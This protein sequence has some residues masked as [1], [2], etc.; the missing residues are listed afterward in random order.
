MERKLQD[1]KP[2][3]PESYRELRCGSLTC[4]GRGRVVRTKRENGLTPI[5]EIVEAL[6]IVLPHAFSFFSF[7]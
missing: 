5:I 7:G 1:L 2:E 3:V 6:G 4:G